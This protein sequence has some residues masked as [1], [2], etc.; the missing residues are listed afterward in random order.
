MNILAVIKR[1][2]TGQKGAAKTSPRTGGY[3]TFNQIYWQQPRDL[4]PFTFYTIYNMLIDPEVRL[5]LSIRAAP[6][7]GVEWAQKNDTGQWQPGIQAARPEV[8]LFVQRQLDRIWHNHIH[9]L[10]KAQIWGWAAGEVTLKLGY[11]QLV[12]VD[13]L[14]PRKAADCRLL[15]SRGNPWGVRVMRIKD[16]GVIDLEFPTAFFHAHDPD[17]GNHYGN[18]VLM[19]AYNPW[20]DKWL[21][22][23]A[24]DVRRLFMHKDAYASADLGYPDGETYVDGQD[25]PVPNRDIARQI[26]EQIRSGNVIVRP[27]ARD[28]SGNEQ[29]PLTRATIP[30]NPSHI[31][32][33]PKDLD[34]EIR[35]GIGLPDQ[36]TDNSGAWAGAR[37]PMAAFYASLDTWVIKMVSDLDTQIIRP[38][39][40]LNFGEQ[41]YQITHKP[42]AQQAM[43]QQSNAGPG[44]P[45]G[46]P[47][48]GIDP[49]DPSGLFGGPQQPDAQPRQQPRL[50]AAAQPMQMSLDPVI[51]VGQGV[52][53]ASELVKAARMA[54]HFTAHAPPGGITIDGV[55]YDGGQFIPGKTQR[56]VDAISADDRRQW[57]PRKV[58]PLTRHKT[59]ESPRN[60][61]LETKEIDSDEHPD[62]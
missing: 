20:A 27:S 47:A 23:G 35:H 29:W 26:V 55:E 11:S 52:L 32:Q 34:A 19:G 44:G 9:D 41:A 58:P 62:D 38:L 1:L 4:P 2:L 12:E 8:G 30:A 51:A 7:S 18:S 36:I 5:A 60:D 21:E 31:L 48:Q 17:P 13:R 14:V 49:T 22:G 39:V 54:M 28:A 50:T 40:T 53:S 10:V 45:V 43:E 25:A 56:E 61:D 33:Y 3:A 46:Q 16:V 37:I 57:E 42:L 6:I 15:L 24:L 59:P